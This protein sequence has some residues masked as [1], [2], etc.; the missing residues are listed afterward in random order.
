[1]QEVEQDLNLPVLKIA[2]L[3]DLMSLLGADTRYA[4]Q[5]PRF[6]AYRE[7]YGVA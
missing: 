3:A 4:A 2:T 6:A 5:L 1:V 7:R